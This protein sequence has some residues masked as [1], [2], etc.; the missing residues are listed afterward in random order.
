MVTA[1]QDLPPGWSRRTGTPNLVRTV[2]AGSV[3]DSVDVPRGGV[4]EIWLRGSIGREVDVLINGRSVG[5]VERELTHPAGWLEL[6][7]VTLRAGP[8][9]VTLSRGEAS[10]APGS[11]DGPRTLG[12]VVLRPRTGETRQVVVPASRWRRLCRLRLAS[13]NAVVPAS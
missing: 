6:G 9:Q 2:G 12:S 8:H 7:E 4:H 13:A 1:K 10:I 11:G 5:S 3:S